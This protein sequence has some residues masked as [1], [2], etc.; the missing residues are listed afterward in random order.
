[1]DPDAASLIFDLNKDLK[2]NNRFKRL[3]ESL[4]MLLEDYSMVSFLPF[5]VKDEEQI[6][7]VIAHVDHMLQYGEDLEVRGMSVR[8]PES[9]RC[10]LPFLQVVFT[11]LCSTEAREW[12]DVEE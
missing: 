10:F 12:D 11:L 3:N 2:E 6:E 8:A 4:G 9:L 5:N 1:M 7:L